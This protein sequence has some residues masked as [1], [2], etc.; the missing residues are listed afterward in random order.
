MIQEE[1]LSEYLLNGMKITQTKGSFFCMAYGNLMVQ[2][3]CCFLQSCRFL[4]GRIYCS[5]CH[6]PF[7]MPIPIH[8]T[9]QLRMTFCFLACPYV[10]FSSKSLYPNQILSYGSSSGLGHSSWT[11]LKSECFLEVGTKL[12]VKGQY[13]SQDDYHQ[14]LKQ[15]QDLSGL[16]K[17]NCHIPLR[18][19]NSPWWLSEK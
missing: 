4:G 5:K 11:E 8:H 14:L 19:S 17:E 2:R 12:F 6:P 10:Q 13:I 1:V 7:L 16:A 3:P 9:R 18:S 15:S